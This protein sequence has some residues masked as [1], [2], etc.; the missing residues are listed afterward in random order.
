MAD[1]AAIHAVYSDPEVMRH[2]G[3]G[4]VGGLAET[5]ATLAAYI[6]HQERHG[7]SFW[8]VVERQSG[9]LIGDAGLYSAEAAADEIELGY[10]LGAARWGRGYATEAARACL[11]VG[12]RELALD[13]I[14]AVADPANAASVHVLDKLGM[15]AAGRRHAYGRPH[16]LYR[17]RRAA[18]AA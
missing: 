2:V 3:H 18:Y 10:T 4:P 5:E 9:A 15:V 7:F 17:L 12:F 16:L 11:D 6:E 14:L 13:E 8:A 1:V